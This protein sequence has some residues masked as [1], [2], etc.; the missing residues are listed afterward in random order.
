MLEKLAAHVQ[1]ICEPDTTKFADRGIVI[2]GGS[3]HFLELW[4]TINTIRDTGCKLPIELWYL[5]PT[6]LSTELADALQPLGVQL[7]DGLEHF[8]ELNKPLKIYALDQVGFT[9]LRKDLFQAHQTVTGFRLKSL[10]LEAAQFKQA[11]LL[12][13]DNSP[14]RDPT[15]LFEHQKFDKYGLLLWRD[16]FNISITRGLYEVYDELGLD[17]NL[18]VPEIESG[19]LVIDKVRRYK[20][21]S[22]VNKMTW[23]AQYYYNWMHGDKDL[24]KLASNYL[25]ESFWMPTKVAQH[26]KDPG[27]SVGMLQIGPDHKPLFWH[28]AGH[29]KL[30]VKKRYYSGNVPSGIDSGRINQLVSEFKEHWH[31]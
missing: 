12:D 22:L 10:A 5:G 23:D 7:K 3:Y 29:A 30:N 8:P 4:V 17:R 28:R 20:V 15:F 26:R 9:G 21:L 11:L 2:C 1:S 18:A 14:Y 13:A 16:K 31:K 24:W 19:Q 27:W 25:G 6:E